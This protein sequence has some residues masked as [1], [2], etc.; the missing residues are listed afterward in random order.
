MFN[1]KGYRKILFY[2]LFLMLS[3]NIFGQSPH[4]KEYKIY[5]NKKDYTVNVIYQDNSGYMW[6]GTSEGLIKF[7]GQDYFYYT[8]ENGLYNNNITALYQDKNNILW[9]GDK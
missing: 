3:F 4:F 2:L 8:G 9:I 5:K 1:N 6:F 7:D